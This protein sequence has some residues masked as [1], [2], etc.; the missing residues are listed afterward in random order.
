[1]LSGLAW[2]AALSLPTAAHAQVQQVS[3]DHLLQGTWTLVRA[4]VIG[5]DGTPGVDPVYGAD[6]KGLLM[7]DRE[8]R[9]SLQIFRPDLPKFAAAD[10]T[11][12]TPAEYQAA[13]IGISTHIGHVAVDTVD[14]TLLFHIE[15]ASFPNS[16]NTDQKRTYRLVNG[17]LSYTVPPRPDG[18]RA[19]S[20]WRRVD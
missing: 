2:V 1:M 15:Y 10:K 17:E 3:G 5:P 18:N 9:Y 8:G 4:E 20:V 7:V 13:V 11:K 16:D 19:V 14:H 12:G 6:A